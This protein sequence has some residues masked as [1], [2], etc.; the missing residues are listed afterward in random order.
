V[1]AGKQNRLAYRRKIDLAELANEPWIL[2]PPDSWTN[3]IM[4]ETFRTRGLDPP[5][6]CLTTSS[7][8]LRVQLLAAGSFI[9]AFPSSMLRLNAN[10]SLLKV[11]PVELPVRP[12]PVAVVTLKNR[13]LSPL[14]Q[15]FVDQIRAF[16]SAM[17]AELK[18]EKSLHPRKS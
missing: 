15:L 1:A 5:K 17:A 10:Q 14:V 7:V 9:T 8:Y 12:W 13:T 3:M 2:T 6:I 18:P 4:A 11:L 16:T